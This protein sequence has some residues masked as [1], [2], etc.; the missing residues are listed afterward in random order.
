MLRK[1]GVTMSE[2]ELSKSFRLFSVPSFWSGVASML[3]FNGE[4]NE[5]NFS[6]SD[7]KADLDSLRDDWRA[8]AQ[9]MEKAIGETINGQ[10]K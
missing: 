3:D 10:K 9:D 6:S 1:A 7:D 2:L 4:L 8:I 5:I